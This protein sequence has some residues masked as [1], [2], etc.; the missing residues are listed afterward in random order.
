MYQ[1]KSCGGFLTEDYARVFGDNENDVYD[2]RHCP[3]D[4]QG[5][6]AEES[7]DGEP[8]LLS[9]IRGTDAGG[10]T[11]DGGSAAGADAPAT[12]AADRSES[13]RR[14]GTGPGRIAARSGRAG[15]SSFLSVFR[16]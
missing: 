3:P 6:T 10:S 5:R 13:D 8:V 11:G 4:E 16:P 12:D 9:E 14:E 2:C 7:G 1:C 15:L